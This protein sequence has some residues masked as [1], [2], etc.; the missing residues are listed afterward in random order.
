MLVSRTRTLSPSRAAPKNIIPYSAD[1]ASWSTK[2]L[3]T[4]TLDETGPD[5]LT[6]SMVA[7]STDGSAQF[8]YSINAAATLTTE[9]YELVFVAK[10]PVGGRPIARVELNN[11]GAKA[12]GWWWNLSTHSAVA[13]YSGT[14]DAEEPR[15]LALPDSWYRYDV[16]VK[17]T[18][19]A[20][21]IQYLIDNGAYTGSYQGDGR[22]AVIVS[23]VGLYKGHYHHRLRRTP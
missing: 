17:P 11:L 5:G 14:W 15:V 19:E 12:A 13:E 8:H 2:A 6:A 21:Y 9:W 3:V 1:L 4:P 10:S 22:D 18:A 23:H 16:Y 7:E 20:A